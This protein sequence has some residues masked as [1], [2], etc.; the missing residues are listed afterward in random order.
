MGE[1]CRGCGSYYLGAAR[2]RWAVRRVS[3]EWKR[4]GGLSLL[5]LSASCRHGLLVNTPLPSYTYPLS[6]C[7]SGR[8]K[9]LF[10]SRNRLRILFYSMLSSQSRHGVTS[11]KH[12]SR[13]HESDSDRPRQPI[14]SGQR[15]TAE[16]GT[17]STIPDRQHRSKRADVS[18]NPMSSEQAPTANKYPTPRDQS[19]ASGPSYHAS[20][21]PQAP[22][23]SLPTA[24]AG[25]PSSNAR[26]RAHELS[27]EPDVHVYARRRTERQSP[28]SSEERL[29]AVDQGK[30]SRS[31][32]QPATGYT[33]TPLAGLPVNSSSIYQSS[34]DP[35]SSSRHHRERDRDR[36]KDRERRR[37]RE[38][39]RERVREEEERVRVRAAA[40]EKEFER[41]KR[42][43]EK[44]AR[45]AEREKEKERERRKEEK[46]LERVRR[47]R[48]KEKA[49]E[50]ELRMREEPRGAVRNSI[51][52]QHPSTAA[53]KYMN[54]S[55]CNFLPCSN[56][57]VRLIHS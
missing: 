44:E 22:L 45:R 40:L 25:E 56:V 34:R 39:E 26:P 3:V 18:G 30:P 35:A 31:S 15:Y 19:F 7:L 51:Y 8:I 21:M 49:R 14:A 29:L 43:E 16:H 52:A 5:R 57:E 17:A 20:S 55:V 33:S 27:H 2:R 48:E 36:E 53:L 28:R 32:R 12:E 13:H 46:E 37:E 41:Q 47:H 50:H 1:R 23:V 11:R 24:P 38:R 6:Y 4:Q 10:C 42:R 9:A 54:G